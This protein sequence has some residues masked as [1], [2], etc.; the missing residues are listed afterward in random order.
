MSYVGSHPPHG[1]L[2]PIFPILHVTHKT[3]ALAWSTAKLAFF[4]LLE[5]IM[6]AP[7]PGP[8]H[9]ILPLPGSLLVAYSLPNLYF[10]AQ[11]LICQTSSSVQIS[12]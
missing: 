5:N 1:K 7:A 10:P 6:L 12:L 4:Q 11:F 8:L 3:Q 9:V 2:H